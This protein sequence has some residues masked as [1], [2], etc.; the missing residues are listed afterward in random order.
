MLP[1]MF[2]KLDLI[3]PKKGKQHL[4]ELQVLNV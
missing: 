2:G 4:T 3:V 1:S